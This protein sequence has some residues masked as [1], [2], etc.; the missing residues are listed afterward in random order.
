MTMYWQGVTTFHWYLD[1]EKLFHSALS[2]DFGDFWHLCWPS[3]FD[4]QVV[5]WI[6]ICTHRR[7][8]HPWLARS[9][10]KILGKKINLLSPRISA[11]IKF[12][13]N[14]TFHFVKCKKT[15]S[16]KRDYCK[17]ASCESSHHRILSTD[18]ILSKQTSSFILEVERLSVGSYQTMPF[19]LVHKA[20]CESKKRVL[21]KI[22]ELSST[23]QSASL[24]TDHKTVH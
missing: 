1:P 15:N 17:E 16:S 19:S 8:C 7:C 11:K 23:L 4:F 3:T 14:S 6:K 24:T 20:T 13:K 18:S 12:N 2:H 5:K 10:I 21:T 9:P 22:F